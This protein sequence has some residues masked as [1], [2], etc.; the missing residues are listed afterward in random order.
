[1]WF[2]YTEFISILHSK[3]VYRV[4]SAC[5][6]QVHAVSPTWTH[7]SKIRKNSLERVGGNHP[8]NEMCPNCSRSLGILRILHEPGLFSH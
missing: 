5:R 4:A 8:P 7:E 6:L 3:T 1:M 2:F